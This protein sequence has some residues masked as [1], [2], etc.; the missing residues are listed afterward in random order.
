MLRT[1]SLRVLA[2]LTGFAA[3]LPATSVAQTTKTRPKAATSTTRK[4]AATAKPAPAAEPSAAA[5]PAPSAAP[6]RDTAA[7]RPAPAVERVQLRSAAP[8]RAPARRGPPVPTVD[9]P[10]YALSVGATT[11]GLGCAVCRA[12]ANTATSIGGSAAW[13]L[14][15]RLSAGVEGL[16]WLHV[17]GGGADQTALGVS[18]IARW[19]PWRSRPVAVTGGVGVVSHRI[20]DGTLQLTSR[21]MLLSLGASYDLPLRGGVWVTPQLTLRM[22][23]PTSLV[24]GNGIA[25]A[26]DARLGLATFGVGLTWF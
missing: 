11:G 16:A 1:P 13:P 23:S 25:F 24:A 2:A 22:T 5:A 7:A 9:G 12:T 6:A 19:Q 20:D 4:P 3:C 10:V 21:A 18:G 17:F 26:R 15:D 14:A 8:S